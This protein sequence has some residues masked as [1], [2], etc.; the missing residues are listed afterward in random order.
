MNKVL[1]EQ[2][3]GQFKRQGGVGS[4]DPVYQVKRLH[5]EASGGLR[6]E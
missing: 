3:R 5:W 4:A 6:W 1:Q 2:R